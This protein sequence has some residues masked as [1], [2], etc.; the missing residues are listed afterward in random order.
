MKNS[1][2]LKIKRSDYK[3]TEND[4]FLDNKAC[5]QLIT[6]STEMDNWGM[7]FNPVLSKRAVKEIS[8][9]KRTEL[10]HRYGERV[11]VFSLVIPNPEKGSEH[12]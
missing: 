12:E 6:Q 7:R 4:K 11:S 1:I 3:I 8:L 10:V 2:T 9:F 5:V